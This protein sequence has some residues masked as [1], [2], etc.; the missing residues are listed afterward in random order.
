MTPKLTSALIL[1]LV[2]PVAAQTYFVPRPSLN[3]G[4]TPP[5]LSPCLFGEFTGDGNPDLI[6]YRAGYIECFVG[7]PNTSF[8]MPGPV[9]S[10][11]GVANTSVNKEM[12]LGPID[13]D[14]DGLND[15]VRGGLFGPRPMIN[16]GGGNFT[17]G[18]GPVWPISAFEMRL[19]DMD[20]VPPLDLCYPE[21]YATGVATAVSIASYDQATMTLIPQFTVPTAPCTCVRTGDFNGDGARDILLCGVAP[22]GA[23]EFSALMGNGLGTGFNPV[24][25]FPMLSTIAGAGPVA[26][27][28]MVADLT[29]DGIDDVFSQ[30]AIPG[31]FSLHV[32]LSAFSNT[33][34]FAAPITITVPW[35][36][37]FVSAGLNL[38][39]LDDIDADGELDLLWGTCAIPGSSANLS[40]W[41]LRVWRGLGGGAFGNPFDMELVPMSDY[42]Y[43]PSFF[44]L[45]DTD[46]D[47]D[48]DLGCI[49]VSWLLWDL[50]VQSHENQ[51]IVGPGSGTVAGAAPPTQLLT[52]LTPGAT[53]TAT[54]V[55][56]APSATT[57]LGLSLN[58]FLPSTVAGP[59]WLDISPSSLLWPT[60]SQGI[61]TTS[62]A[63]SASISVGIPPTIPS[64][65]T[66]FSQWIVQDA[67]GGYTLLGSSWTVSEARTLI[68]F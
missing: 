53:A 9:Q 66:L 14:G 15:F 13:L 24:G 42:D 37:C 33:A 32:G 61:F 4:A 18:G 36:A 7:A 51:A 67:A 27:N 28:P 12:L 38:P 43:G 62:P 23:M 35:T 48:L 6:T 55:G 46:G 44:D 64:G 1:I 3:I 41:V 39:R 54:L 52:P 26:V 25:P 40:P 45:E 59:I 60:P 8:G 10:P 68:V 63:G 34:T 11:A 5:G 47:G 21:L 65:T 58:A 50:W 31:T 29:G 20:G 49:S 30:T 16:Q 57:A 19:D 2:A 17:P 56:A 22:G